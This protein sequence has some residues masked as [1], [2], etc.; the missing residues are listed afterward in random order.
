MQGRHV[1]HASAPVTRGTKAVL[2]MNFYVEGDLWRP[3]S[4]DDPDYW[5]HPDRSKP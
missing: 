2:A 1:R 5:K 4:L 3:E